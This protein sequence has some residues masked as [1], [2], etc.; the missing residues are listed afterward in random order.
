ME[1]RFGVL[2]IIGT[3]WKVLAWIELIVGTLSAFGVLLMG[4][5]GSGSF[6]LQFLGERANVI[7]GAMGLVSSIVAFIALLVGTIVYFLVLYA[8]GEL[9]FLMLA[10]EENTRGTRRW[11][12]QAAG[13]GSEQ[14]AS[15][16]P[17]S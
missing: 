1:K 16:P 12:E 13:G 2:R 5:L 3:L 4:I 6:L 7:P 11:L 17:T 15:P 14:A 8:V 9:M 10:I